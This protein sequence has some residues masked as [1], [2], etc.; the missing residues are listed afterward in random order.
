MCCYCWTS[1]QRTHALSKSQPTRYTKA[2]FE[3][4]HARLAEAEETLSA[5]R[6]GNVD[7]IAVDGPHGR[8][9]FTLESTDQPYRVLAERM[10]EGAATV[11]ADGT[12]MFCN[13]RLADMIGLPPAKIVGSAVLAMVAPAEHAQ[14][15]GLMNAALEDESRGE[16]QFRR[17]DGSLVP[18]LASMKMIPTG[19]GVGLCLIATDLTDQKCT[20]AR[21]RE[22]AALLDLAH[23]AI[24]LRDL[25]GRILFWNQGATDLY[26]WLSEEAVG[27]VLHELLHTQFPE[28]FKKIQEFILREKVWEGEL[29][30]TARDG[31]AVTVGSR[32][33]LLRD[34]QGNPT[35]I[36]A[37]SRD[38]T[39]R[40]RL[41]QEAIQSRKMEAIG[42]LAGG[43]AHDLNNTLGVIVGYGDLIRERHPDAE[44]DVIQHV[45]EI[46]RA[47][48]RAT[49]M[50]QQLL[51]FSR[52]QVMQ[53]KAVNLNEIVTDVAK[54]L[55]SLIGENIEVALKTADDLGIAKVDPGQ[56][57]QVLINLAINARD[58]MPNGGQ[59]TIVTANLESLD[60]HHPG[61]DQ[62]VPAGSY[63]TVSVNDTGIGMNEQTLSHIFEPFFTTKEAGRGT[64]FGL[65]IVYGIVKQSGGY[66]SA[67]SKPGQGA[68]FEVYLPRVAEQASK[69]VPLA[70]FSLTKATSSAT[71]LVVEDEEAM[72]EM[73]CTVL[74]NSGH[75][76]L[77]AASGQAALRLAS[78]HKGVI[79]LM[80]SDV[81]LKGKMDGLELA[82]QFS[83]LQPAAKVLFMSGYSDALNRAGADHSIKLL[84]KPFTNA[85]LRARVQEVL[86]GDYEETRLVPNSSLA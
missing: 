42:R 54:M 68:T 32:W 76:V 15:Q 61:F 10:N 3:K 30:N 18:V 26:G 24:L 6:T 72:A 16:V 66:I 71:I 80:L 57:H 22:H 7:A 62:P 21:L 39:E 37:I 53:L 12:V 52:K 50:T 38:I 17:H 35:S 58:A 48:T 28:D 75:V 25:D 20:E 86:G 79:D 4:L 19:S 82:R 59:L 34:G 44:S 63:V 55:R 43:I 56:I 69:I 85:A 49:A 45:S 1:E 29:H 51:A 13:Q 40:K 31:R 77:Q 64:G 83:K 14:F 9:I 8:H 11:S 84:E 73:V 41:E 36:L 70:P 23:D 78:D 74:Q 60:E 33:S 65:S 47:A 81:I 46:G 5:I 2:E 27:K 67:S